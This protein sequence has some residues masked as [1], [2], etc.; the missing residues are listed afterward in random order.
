MSH[1]SHSDCQT[2]LSCHINNLLDTQLIKTNNNSITE[3]FML[4]Y[5]MNKNEI[6]DSLVAN[7]SVF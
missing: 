2:D 3:G 6:R 5:K 7:R 1:D 4:V